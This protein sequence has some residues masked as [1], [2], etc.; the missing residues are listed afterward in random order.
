MSIGA[1]ELWSVLTVETSGCGFLPDR[2]P[3]IL[4]ERH[5]FRRETGG[6]FD[7]SNPEISNRTP[8]GYGALGAYQYDRLQQAL[9]LD[10]KAA[11]RSASWGIGQT[12]GFNA[13]IAG[14]SDVEAL[15]NG[16]M[17]SETEQLRAM[18]QMITHN[19]LHKALSAHN[20]A[21]FA[22]GYNG[23]D[24]AKNNYDTRLAEAYNKYVNG[25]L[26]D[27]PARAAQMYLTYLGYQPGSI[28]GIAGR[29]TYAA[30][31]VFQQQNGLPLTQE[32]NEA[33]LAILKEKV[34]SQT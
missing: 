8:G 30:L 17:V 31:N 15:V 22:G 25:P 19:N 34:L 9:A 16:M 6:R 29:A 24:Y 32:I 12:M 4:F 26:P 2:R 3:K 20:W 14:Y 5:I 1:A 10:R 33:I 18:A 27:L 28:D 11:L 13:E 23:P 21:A 7:A